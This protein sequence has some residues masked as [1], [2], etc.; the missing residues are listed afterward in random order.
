MHRSGLAVFSGTRTASFRQSTFLASGMINY[1][2]K[3]PNRNELNSLV[4]SGNVDPPLPT[5]HPFSSVISYDYWSGTS[6]ASDTSYVWILNFTSGNV[7]LRSKSDDLPYIWPV[8]G[9][10]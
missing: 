6:F 8:R 2:R 9:G 4:D 5:G 3:L 10:N 7:S 1:F